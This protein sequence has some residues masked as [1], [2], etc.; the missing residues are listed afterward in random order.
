MRNY[1]EN[2]I[3]NNHLLY[4]EPDPYNPYGLPP[5]T[6]RVKYEAGTEPK[7]HMG[8]ATVVD[9]SQNI[10]DITCENSNWR[11]LFGEQGGWDSA[12]NLI[13]V[14]GAN[15]TGVTNMSG[16]FQFC[17]ALKKVA[18]FD[19]SSVT[20]MDSMFWRCA[21]TN[22]PLFDTSNVT[23]MGGMFSGCYSLTTV[24]LFDT[25]NVTSMTSMF[26]GCS[27]LTTVPLFNTGKVTSM[28]ALCADCSSLKNI[29]L[30]ELTNVTDIIFIFS[31]CVN[32]ESG[33]Y[34]FYSNA[35]HHFITNHLEA[36]K[37]CGINTPTGAAELARI[38]DEWK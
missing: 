7:Y 29:P 18:I 36:F 1:I 3:F 16:L 6:I 34:A 38:P 28:Y 2:K 10:W 33:S 20:N 4:R 14:L 15:T 17:M 21:I 9:I 32:V 24:P 23:N 37:N 8:T 22:I 31:G 26:N 11:Y 13:E 25:K 5:Y 19:T 12:D 30:L 35:N 27:S